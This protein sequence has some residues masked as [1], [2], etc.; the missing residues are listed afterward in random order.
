M[1]SSNSAICGDLQFLAIQRGA[2]AFIVHGLLEPLSNFCLS[3]L[4]LNSAA[5]KGGGNA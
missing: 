4:C 2:I 3:S 5:A 1:A